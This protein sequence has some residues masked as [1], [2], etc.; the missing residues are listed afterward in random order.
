MTECGHFFCLP[1]ITD[2]VRHSG[3]GGYV[4]GRGSGVVIETT[5]SHTSELVGALAT[6]LDVPEDH[7]LGIIH[8][9][10]ALLEHAGRRRARPEQLLR[11]V[12]E[13]AGER[14]VGE[15]GG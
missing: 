4:R 8:A 2:V 14:D 1:C 5:R 10:I 6:T 11:A 9:Q 3:R 13:F 7:L 12:V 15:L